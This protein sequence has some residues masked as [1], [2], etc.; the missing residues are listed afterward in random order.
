MLEGFYVHTCIQ[1]H[2]CVCVHMWRSDEDILSLFK[3]LSTVVF[4]RS[5]PEPEAYPLG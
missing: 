2:V 5:F 3:S 4:E 1:F